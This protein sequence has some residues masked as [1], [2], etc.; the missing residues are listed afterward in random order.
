VARD[1]HRFPPNG[2]LF[3][4]KL[5][6]SLPSEE[7]FTARIPLIV[8]SATKSALPVGSKE[9][10]SEMSPQTAKPW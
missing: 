1:S 8:N 9:I 5:G 4:F 7:R 2:Q 6:G 10:R 3:S